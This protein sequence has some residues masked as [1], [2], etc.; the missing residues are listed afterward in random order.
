MPFYTSP[1][2]NFV[3]HWKGNLKSFPS[4][5]RVIRFRLLSVGRNAVEKKVIFLN[6]YL[7]GIFRRRFPRDK[8]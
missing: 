2:H 6:K 3:H 7:P 4:M 8:L 1:E 5:Y